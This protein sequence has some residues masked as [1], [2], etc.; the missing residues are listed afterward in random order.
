MTRK[1]ALIV[2]ALVASSC[3]EY[4]PT[5]E[6]SRPNPMPVGM[7]YLGTASTGID[8][9]PMNGCRVYAF[10]LEGYYQTAVYCP[11]GRVSTASAAHEKSSDDDDSL[12]TASQVKPINVT[13]CSVRLRSR[14]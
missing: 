8:G 13:A 7:K 10:K 9:D 12:C 1:F 14:R 11:S 3:K 4:V 2:L 6:A 5:S